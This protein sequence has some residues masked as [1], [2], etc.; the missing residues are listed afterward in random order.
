MT[1]LGFNS[2]NFIETIFRLAFKILDL[3]I[4]STKSIFNVLKLLG[5]YISIKFIG[6]LFPFTDLKI[7][8]ISRR[9]INNSRYIYDIFTLVALIDSKVLSFLCQMK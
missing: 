1:I 6:Y 2:F 4:Q 5:N 3:G 7:P 8:N 9:S